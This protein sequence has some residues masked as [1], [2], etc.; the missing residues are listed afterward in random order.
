MQLRQ[1]CA[2]LSLCSCINC[3]QTL[4]ESAVAFGM[5]KALQTEQ[6]KNEMEGRI[7]SLE[8]EVKDLERQV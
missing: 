8:G 4:Y 1:C 7:Q 3:L 5:R 2:E 6:G